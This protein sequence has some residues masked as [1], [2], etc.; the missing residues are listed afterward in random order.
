[1]QLTPQYSL[2]LKPIGTFLILSS[3]KPGKTD[4]SCSIATKVSRLYGMYLYFLHK[5]YS[6]S[7]VIFSAAVMPFEKGNVKCV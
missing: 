6:H 7:T 5:F 3:D 2:P 4:R 1:M